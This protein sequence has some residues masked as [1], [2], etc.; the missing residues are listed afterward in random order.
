MPYVMI[1]SKCNMRCAHCCYSCGPSGRHMTLDTFKFALELD[2]E[3]ISIGGGEPTVH[4]HFWKFLGLAIA[5]VEYVWLATNGKDTKAALALAKMA[6]KGVISCALSL[7]CYHEP[8]DKK[9][10]EAFQRRERNLDSMRPDED[11]RE[12][13][14]VVESNPGVL[15]IGRGAEILG[16]NDGCPCPELFVRPNGDVLLCGCPDAPKL[17]NLHQKNIQLFAVPGD[18]CWKEMKEQ[19]TLPILRRQ[20]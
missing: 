1:T 11:C 13:R 10:V 18:G 2:C 5:Q 19:G 16:A 12:I 20:S 3:S 6:K 7:D 9:V 17:C 8:I 4:P 14:N 15:A